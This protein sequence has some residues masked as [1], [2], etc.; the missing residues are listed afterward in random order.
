MADL[1]VIIPA[2]NEK[3]LQRTIESV[4]AASEVD[5]EIIAICDGYW[6]DPPIKDHPKVNLIHHS[7]ARGQRPSINEAARIAQGKFLM[8]LDAHC[9]VGPGFGRILIE[10]W[11]PGW[12]I[13]PRMYNLDI[14]TWRPRFYPDF[15]LAG[16]HGKVHDYMYAGWNHKGELRAQ[17]YSGRLW[18]KLHRRPALLDETMCC[19]GP[20]WFL[21]KE[22]FWKQGGCDEN[23]GHWGQQGIEV[24]LKAW[25]SGGALMVDKR[26]WFAH[27]FRGGGGPGFPYPISQRSIDQ[28]RQYSM[29]L[30]LN[31]KWEGQTRAFRWL[32]E[33][34]NPPTWEEVLTLTDPKTVELSEKLYHHIHVKGHEPNW[35]G[36]RVVKQ[37]TDMIQYQEVIFENKP[38]F[39]VEAGTKFGGSAL[40]FQDML[41]IVGQG[42]RVIT[43]DIKDFVKVKDPRITYILGSSTDR[44][45]V[46]KV[47]EMVG[48][49]TCMVV[50]DSNHHRR[51]VKWELHHYAPMVTTGQY[52]VIEDCYSRG[53]KP[54]GP[55]E[56]RDWFLRDTKEGRK[57]Q[58]TNLERR[59]LVG[60]CAGGWLR[61]RG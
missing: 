59:F 45:I 47:R 41:D 46:A 19:M 60:V 39:I 54:F 55:L 61:R 4:L 49:E 23:H 57:F 6:P 1:T 34:F 52:L 44:E 31:D 40:F 42:G 43:I 20:G 48:N 29:D 5:T 22:D 32:V 50:L 35:R 28:A 33:K 15:E 13:V 58:Q 7:E 56:A 9:A 53:T 10:D 8:K 2:R 37:P 11:K 30:W 24:S 21:S 12:T 25:L 26:T 18:W 16:T 27:W 14:E 36:I 51:H 38:K 17:Y 3:Y